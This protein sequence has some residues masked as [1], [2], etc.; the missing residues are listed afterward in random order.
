MPNSFLS[1]NVP[2]GDGVGT[3]LNVSTLARAKTVT[4]EGPYDGLLFVE[5]STDGTNFS[6]FLS[7]DGVSVGNGQERPLTAT[8]QFMR[9]RRSQ[10]ADPAAGTPVV[11][12]GAQVV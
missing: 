9:I 1:L 11:G 2:A 7:L 3:N 4:I 12:V 8:L 5:G 6:P 10:V